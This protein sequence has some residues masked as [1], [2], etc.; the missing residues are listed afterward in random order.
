MTMINRYILVLVCLWAGAILALDDYTAAPTKIAIPP[1][2]V[3]ALRLVIL[4]TQGNMQPCIDELE[5]FGPGSYKNLALAKN[6]AIASASSCLP[7]YA[8][9]AVKHL[10]DGRYGN[11]H[12]WIPTETN[13]GWAKITFPEPVQINE[14]VY[15]RD[16]EGR[17]RDRISAQIEIQLLDADGQWRNIH[18]SVL[19]TSD[20]NT[21]PEA[22]LPAAPDS[23]RKATLQEIAFQNEEY[24][25]LL[26]NSVVDLHPVLSQ[27]RYGM[28]RNGPR[29]RGADMLPLPVLERAPALTFP[30][31]NGW[32]QASSGVVHVADLSRPGKS[33]LSSYWAAAGVH[34]DY[35]YLEISASRL[36]SSHVAVVSGMDWQ[37]CGVVVAEGD[38][39]VFN[40]YTQDGL[41]HSV[42]VEGSGDDDSAFR[43]RL[44]L[45]QFPDALKTGFRVGLG[46]GGKYTPKQGRPIYFRPSNITMTLSDQGTCLRP[47]PFFELLLGLN[48]QADPVKIYGNIPALKEGLLLNPGETRQFLVDTVDTSIG[49]ECDIEIWGENEEKYRSHRISYDQFFLIGRKHANLGERLRKKG[50]NA[51][52]VQEGWRRDH[53]DADGGYTRIRESL[54]QHRT[55]N[56][57]L[58]FSD[59]DLASLERVLFVKRQPFMPSHNY[60]V[61]LDAPWRAGGAICTL[62]IPR[63]EGRLVP[64]EA[65]V[66]TL[67][68]AGEGIARTPAASFDASTIYFSYRASR[69]D[70]F[71]I[72]KMNADGSDVVQLTTGPFHDYWPCPLPDGGLAFI[73]T[74]CKRRFL[75]WRPQAATMHRMEADGSGIRALSFANLTEW[76]PSVM[77]DGRIIWTRSEYQDKAADFG[78]TLWAIRPDGTQP[79]LVF[80]NTITL[81]NGYANGRYVPGTNEVAATLISHFGDL[82]GPIALLDTDKGRFNPDAIT[83]ITPEVFWPGSPPSEECFRDPVPISKDHFLVS[84]ASRDRFDLYVIDRF[85]NREL[86]Y[87]DPDISSMCP[88]IFQART[89]PPVLPSVIDE[90]L[91]YGEFLVRDVYEGTQPEIEPGRAAYLSVSVEVTHDLETLDNGLLRADHEPFQQF[92]ASP[93]DVL[94]G[95]YGWPTYAAKQNLGVVPIEEDGSAHFKA[96]SGKVLFFH[97]L[98]ED[99]N[100]LQRMRSVVQLQPGE[101]RSCVGCHESRETA[102]VP[103]DLPI[104]MT[105]EA[106]PIETPPWGDD[107]FSFEQVVQPVLDAHCVE[108]HDG[109]SENGLD[110]SDTL[111]HAKIPASY[112]TMIS[113]GLVHYADWTWSKPDGCAKLPPLSLGTLKSRLWDV[114]NAGH[115]DVRLN[116]AAERAIKTWIDLNCPLWGDYTERSK[117][118]PWKKEAAPKWLAENALKV[119]ARPIPAVNIK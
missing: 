38:A 73:S 97:I 34:G 9:H 107:A 96:P 47:A 69:E 116:I 27:A 103:K 13:G 4:S 63:R 119:S 37:G 60:S 114:L 56:R 83:S 39:L 76:A 110:F 12:S 45:A 50:V 92:Y 64:E 58:F 80:G 40:T 105:Y 100:E 20:P 17:F 99:Y 41:A 3:Q 48:R 95:P 10:N 108:C 36:L 46:M 118:A 8:A 62:E 98:D 1:Q 55:L 6:G 71:H 30:S 79:E 85:G 77:E 26:A 14:L 52:S 44:P 22:P 25:G 84:H 53:P 67:F 106:R 91:D 115:H 112:R 18:K 74:R 15:S 72:Y 49:T 16:R 2:E 109:A 75:C 51:A 66:R 70:Y 43:M 35:L 19:I 23:A 28:E 94:T 89:P 101:K 104:A 90:S 29:A 24:A 87:A 82:N 31:E 21:I 59:P 68:E 7:G 86:L 113:K 32:K 54:N 65:T 57:E 42:A 88:T 61:L 5:I 111:D 93:S 117:R 78:H 102:Y 11:A 33:A 81:A